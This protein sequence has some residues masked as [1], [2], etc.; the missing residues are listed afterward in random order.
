M[1]KY[2]PKQTVLSLGLVLTILFGAL[3]IICIV[4]SGVD[5]Q[6]TDM[7]WTDVGPWRHL[8]ALQVSSVVVVFFIF[9]MGLITFTCGAQCK[10]IQLMFVMLEFLTMI[11]TLGL[12]SL[13]LLLVLLD[14]MNIQRC[15]I[16]IIQVSLRISKCLINLCLK[17]I[18]LFAV[19]NVCVI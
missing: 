13:H 2:L 6:Q 11:L 9:L 14:R 19:K 10:T 1:C 17:L 16:R 5:Y 4:I 12:L 18:K 15:V 8:A 7:K 3:S